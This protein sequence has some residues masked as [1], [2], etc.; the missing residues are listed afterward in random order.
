[1]KN[2]CFTEF[3]HAKWL[4]KVTMYNGHITIGQDEAKLWASIFPMKWGAKE[5]S[6]P[7]T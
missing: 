7:T 6:F 5:H 3:K 2:G 1:M 4:L